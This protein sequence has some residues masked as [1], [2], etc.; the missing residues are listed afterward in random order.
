MQIAI[1]ILRLA[2]RAVVA[3][4][5]LGLIVSAC[6]ALLVG[7]AG[8]L[9]VVA[10]TVFRKPIPIVSEISAD[11]L[12]VI[13]F[14]A[15]GY[16]QHRRAHISVDIVTAYLPERARKVMELLALLVS[17]VFLGALAWQAGDL[18][19]ESFAVR[20]SAMALI[21]YPVYPF[22]IAFL[23][24]LGLVVLEL[25]RQIIWA[26]LSWSDDRRSVSRP[27]GVKG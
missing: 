7:L 23:I 25:V 10:S 1:A 24:G 21:P 18:A 16:A 3:L 12:A 26:F 9:D 14:L 19:R 20:E 5:K 17:L 2:D 27:T 13:I 11:A 15:I 22:K 6:T 8:A 4:V